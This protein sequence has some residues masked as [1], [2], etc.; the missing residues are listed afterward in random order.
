MP[1]AL[2]CSAHLGAPKQ[3]LYNLQNNLDKGLA[4]GQRLDKYEKNSLA[5]E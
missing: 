3:I 1:A 2:F 4:D 5:W